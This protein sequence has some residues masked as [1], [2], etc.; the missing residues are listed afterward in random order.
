MHLRLQ[1]LFLNNTHV[2]DEG[3]R[4]LRHMM[5]LRT[6]ALHETQITDTALEDVGQLVNLEEWLGLSNTKVSDAGLS[7]LTNLKKLRNLNLIGTDVSRDGLIRLRTALPQTM[8]SPMPFD[9]RYPG[10]TANA[11]TLE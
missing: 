6:L 5:T 1:T 3:I 9:P 2:T 7:K 8:V 4:H 11:A 10:S